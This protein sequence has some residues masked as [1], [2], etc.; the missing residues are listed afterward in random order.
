MTWA[1]RRVELAKFLAASPDLNYATCCRRKLFNMHSSPLRRTIL[2]LPLLVANPFTVRAEEYVSASV[3]HRGQLHIVL[4]SGKEIMPPKARW[5]VSFGRPVISPD[6]R[7]VGWYAMCP[8]PSYPADQGYQLEC[9]LVI[10]RAERVLHTFKGEAVLWDWQF[11]NGGRRV[12]YSTGPTHRGATACVLRDVESG[13]TVARWRVG[14]AGEPPAW[15][16]GLRQ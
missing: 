8:D 11:R 1:T 9:A 3:D 2:L 13:R 5:Q 7:T 6:R 14:E 10:Y 15:A 16:K 12:A 4:A